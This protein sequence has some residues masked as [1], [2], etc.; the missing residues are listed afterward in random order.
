MYVYQVKKEVQVGFW[1]SAYR[2]DKLSEL[3]RRQE[4]RFREEA[5]A[6]LA[7]V[8]DGVRLLVLG[9]WFSGCCFRLLSAHRDSVWKG[10]K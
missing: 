9:R 1:G 10:H 4:P 6:E 3:G 8:G 7:R 2:P 5:G